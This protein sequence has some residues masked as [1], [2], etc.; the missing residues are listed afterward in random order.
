MKLT[1]SELMQVRSQG[2]YVT[3]KCDGCGKVLNQTFRY[4]IAGKPEVYCS[5]VC[6]DSVFFGS[7]EK[8]VKHSRPGRCVACGASLADK[9]R[10]ALYC[11]DGCRKRHARLNNAASRNNPDIDPM[12]SVGCKAQNWQVGQMP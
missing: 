10:G 7:V 4:A 9:R 3:E 1:P 2:V 5:A 11:D 6:R 12:E 8:A